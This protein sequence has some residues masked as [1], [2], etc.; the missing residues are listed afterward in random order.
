MQHRSLRGPVRA[1]RTT[2][3]EAADNRQEDTVDL[4]VL[5]RPAAQRHEELRGGARH[6]AAA[7][8]VVP[9]G[10]VGR[11]VDGHEAALAELR[12][13]DDQPVRGHIGEL[14]RECLGDPQAASDEEPKQ[15]AIG[16]RPQRAW[17]AERSGRLQEPADRIGR[18][19][20]RPSPLRGHS[21]HATWGDLVPAVFGRH[22]TREADQDPKAAVA[23]G[24]GRHPRGPR[25]G[26]RAADVSFA[27]FGGE[28]REVA[29]Q[30]LRHRELIAR[31]ATNG[32]VEVDGSH[33]HGGTSS[34]QQRATVRSRGT[35]TFA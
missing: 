20:V 19:D 24:Q 14:Q 27:A 17:R 7:P 9:D 15:R 32:E 12:P 28:P 11:L 35:S 26:A 16:V 4:R 13:A 22:V 10:P 31:G 5:H 21:E 23:L 34:G 1:R 2:Q 30:V 8:D 3:A 25:D 18:E 33:Q 6:V 29:Q